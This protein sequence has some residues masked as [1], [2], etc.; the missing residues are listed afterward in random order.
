M[1]SYSLHH[2]ESIYPDSHEFK[3][4]RW[5]DATPDME[6]FLASFSNGTRQCIAIK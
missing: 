4:E 1:D 5:L 2:D 6:R 3:P